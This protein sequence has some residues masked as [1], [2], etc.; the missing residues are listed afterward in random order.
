MPPI[1]TPWYLDKALYVTLLA[2]LAA[3]L[4]AILNSKTGLGLDPVIVTALIA[5]VIVTGVG[6]I[7]AHKW[8][9][10]TMGAAQIAAGGVP[11]TEVAA[12]PSKAV[13]ADGFAQVRLLAL[14]AA[15]AGVCVLGSSC[16]LLKPFP[17][18]AKECAQPLV[19]EAPQLLIDLTA[20]LASGNWVALLDQALVDSGPV[21]Y[22][23]V[24]A[25]VADLEHKAAAPAGSAMAATSGDGPTPT[26]KLIR[27]QTW[28][29]VR[30]Q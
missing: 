28:L 25:I 7:A 20:A 16:A 6:Y 18:Q 29:A 22:C 1:V 13:K 27:A 9:T 23:L 26:V 3:S 8:K 21:V 11:G 5:G 17:G 2:P 30:H 24:A 10:G 14:L 19:A 12:G 15:V 4:V